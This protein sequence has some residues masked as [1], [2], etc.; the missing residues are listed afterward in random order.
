[1]RLSV[2]DKLD[3]EGKT[4]Y[5]KDINGKE[6]KE[7]EIERYVQVRSSGDV[8][9]NCSMKPTT[10]MFIPASFEEIIKYV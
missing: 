7:K 6:T 10:P 3:A 8:D 2:Y 5:R 1:M 4:V 9:L